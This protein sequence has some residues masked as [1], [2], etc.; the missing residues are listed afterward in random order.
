MM[1]M[2][3]DAR[4]AVVLASRLGRRDRPALSPALW[5]RLVQALQDA[6]LR[7]GDL[8][9]SDVDAIG[10][11]AIP[12]ELAE[13]IGVLIEDTVAVVVEIDTL[14]GKGIQP[15]TIEDAAYPDRYGSKLG[16][17]APPVLFVVGDQTL[18]ERDGVGIVGSRNVDEEGA[19]V[20]GRLAEEAARAGRTV[21][22]GGARGVDQLAM[23]AAFEAGGSV[24]GVL[25]DSLA[26]RIRRPD[27][28][29]ALD[30]GQICLITHQHPGAGFG[31]GAAIGRNKLI[32]ALAKL[33]VVVATDRGRG[34]TWEG[35][36]EA[37]RSGYGRVAVW[38]GGGE[39]PGN[40]AL[41]DL[42]AEPIRAVEELC[43]LVDADTPEPPAQMSM[44]E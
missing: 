26:G 22:S 28:L 7:P 27:T 11:A 37:L 20:A 23:A 21:I 2:T 39:G 9:R 16:T 30:S 17:Q 31:A 3:E 6:G 8:L 34:G 32:Y 10:K 25:A 24:V 5:H 15:V 12:E 35:A 43:G 14:A 38:R 13:R 4:A 44:L 19:G 33:T 41:E 40:A 29:R 1:T 42:G 36:S 18:L